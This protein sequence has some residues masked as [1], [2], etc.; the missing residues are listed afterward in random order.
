MSYLDD[1][2]QEIQK[3]KSSGFYFIRNTDVVNLSTDIDAEKYVEKY[4]QE[5]YRYS[6]PLH[7][8]SEKFENGYRVMVMESKM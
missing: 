8:V 2:V 3:S 1:A 5:N 7:V 6:G 4:Y